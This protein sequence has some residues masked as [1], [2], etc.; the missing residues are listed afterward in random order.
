MHNYAHKFTLRLK[1]HVLDQLYGRLITIYSKSKSS[2]MT[3]F[4]N[5]PI[6]IATNNL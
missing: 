5:W 3:Q 4:V 6:C 2:I 1:H